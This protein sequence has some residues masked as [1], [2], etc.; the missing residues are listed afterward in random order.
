VLTTGPEGWSVVGLRVLSS[1]LFPSPLYAPRSEASCPVLAH[2]IGL[3]SSPRGAKRWTWLRLVSRFSS[4][5]VMYWINPSSYHRLRQWMSAATTDAD[6]ALLWHTHHMIL[7]T[8]WHASSLPYAGSGVST[9]YPEQATLKLLLASPLFYYS[10]GSGCSA[11]PD[12]RDTESD[13][14]RG[15]TLH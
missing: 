15:T 13:P 1:Y 7:K 2:L 6:I 8:S 3:H 14:R 9:M 12:A 11:D 10:L 5:C 4:S